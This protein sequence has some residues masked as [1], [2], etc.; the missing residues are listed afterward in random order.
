M[1]PLTTFQET[2]RPQICTYEMK[3]AYTEQFGSSGVKPRSD[4]DQK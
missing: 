1:N 3:S 4:S 2:D